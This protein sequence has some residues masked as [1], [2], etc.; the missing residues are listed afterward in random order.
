MKKCKITLFFIQCNSLLSLFSQVCV[1]L[2]GRLAG[3]CAG[4]DGHAALLAAEVSGSGGH[5]HL[6]AGALWSVGLR[7]GRGAG[8]QHCTVSTH[9]SLCFPCVFH[10]GLGEEVWIGGGSVGWGRKC[11]FGEKVWVW[12]GSLGWGR[13]RG[14][15]RKCS[16]GGSVGWGE[17]RLGECRLGRKC[18]LGEV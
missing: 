11:G 1:P 8:L 6:A 12:G 16:W 9:G 4:H 3:H 5:Q 2:L 10:G 7:H 18:R 15:G 13:K 14:F 17:C